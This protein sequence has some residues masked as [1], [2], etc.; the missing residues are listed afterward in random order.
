L[1]LRQVLPCLL[2]A[3]A[4]LASPSRAQQLTSIAVEGLVNVNRAA[5]M[6]QINTRL[7][8][9]FDINKARDD[10]RRILTLGLFDPEGSSV[11]PQRT[12]QGTRLIFTLK[13]NPLITDVTVRG[14]TVPAV[15][16][17]AI[18]AAARRRY[19]PNSVLNFNAADQLELDVA[20][21]YAEHGYDATINWPTINEDGVVFIVVEETQ[22]DDV[23]LNVYPMVTYLDMEALVRWIGLRD[24]M[25]LNNTQLDERRD[26]VL[27][28][29]IFSYLTVDLLDGERGII[30]SF[31]AILRDYPVPSVDACA[32]IKPGELIKGLPVYK[33][34]PP[35]YSQL[36]TPRPTPRR[37]AK[38]RAEASNSPQDARLAAALA[39]EL[40][41]AGRVTEAQ[42]AATAAVPLLEAAGNEPAT[43][44]LLARVSLLLGAAARA[45]AILDPLRQAGQ[46][47]PDGYP[48]L[49]QAATYLL[50][51]GAVQGEAAKR[52][53]GD[54][55]AWAVK[56]L[57]QARD[58]DALM[59]SS[60]G[61]AYASALAGA[62]ETF[63]RMDERTLAE[64]HLAYERFLATVMLLE[65]LPKQF[66]PSEIVPETLEVLGTP[67]D[68]IF[69]STRL[70]NALRSRKG[71]D[72]GA[73]YAWATCIVQ[74]ELA[75]SLMTQKPRTNE[76]DA[77]AA[78]ELLQAQV[79]LAELAD[80]DPAAYGGAR[81]F[82]A[83]ASMV[84]KEDQKA[85][86]TIAA[87]MDTPD[88]ED[89][90]HL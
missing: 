23:V 76:E 31:S 45:L 83:L 50:A 75:V 24:G 87:L 65:H 35:P 16:K 43:I 42:A 66:A 59:A 25:P 2:L 39:L 73:K 12:D 28:L 21:A 77:K 27:G 51:D 38:L 10:L 5:V 81:V 26:A 44:V 30:V 33:I 86:D 67:V 72:P 15:D 17:A 29:G 64:N 58:W 88:A 74:R 68:P 13:E 36:L 48:A 37:I 69:N 82:I 85:L 56:T 22:I 49:M 46:L 78:E 55:L 89:A 60:A 57:I 90:D 1:T 41:H 11:A 14:I 6:M 63:R 53:P 80:S 71:D 62:W 20:R 18:E 79:A 8:D 84:R 32:F 70:L 19:P 9:E 4:L 52:L 7:G 34:A 3:S 40:A 54:T 47:P 61:A